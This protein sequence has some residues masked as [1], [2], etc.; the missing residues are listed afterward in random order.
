[1]FLFSF[2]LLLSFSLFLCYFLFLFF[3]VTFFFS[4]SLLLSF[5]LFFF[6]LRK[7]G[8]AKK[9]REKESKV[10]RNALMFISLIN[11][12]QQNFDLKIENIP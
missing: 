7:G 5:S 6:S 9:K 3:F 1:F 4:F 10:F 8:Q 2:S 11:F 12:L